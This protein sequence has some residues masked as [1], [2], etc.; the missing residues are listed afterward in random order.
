MSVST[1][2]AIAQNAGSL[3]RLRQLVGR[4]DDAAMSRD[5]GD[6]WTVSAALA[7]LAFWDR[8]SELR[9][10]MWV[11]SGRVEDLDGPPDLVNDAT[12]PEWRAMPPDAV[13]RLVIEAATAVNRAVE[14]GGEARVT[15]VTEAGKPR[16]ARRHL[17]RMEH[18]A[19]IEAALARERRLSLAS[20]RYSAS[21]SSPTLAR[22]SSTRAGSAI[23]AGSNPPPAAGR[24][25]VP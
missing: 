21:G 9:W 6:G 20:A 13:R 8:V 12:L 3:D 14:S 22:R 5:L 25:C 15:A 19:Q 18:I 24:S 17:H 1:S 10:R 7:H 16:W 23:G 4:L 2:D 11:A